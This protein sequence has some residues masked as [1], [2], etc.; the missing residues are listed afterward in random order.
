M[1]PTNAS[2]DAYTGTVPDACIWNNPDTQKLKDIFDRQRDSVAIYNR[3]NDID[4]LK[5][6]FVRANDM[7]ATSMVDKIT[8]LSNTK[9]EEVK[10]SFSLDFAQKKEQSKAIEKSLKK[11]ITL[12]YKSTVRNYKDRLTRMSLTEDELY[13]IKYLDFN[14]ALML[15]LDDCQAQIKEWGQD[16]TVNQMFFQGRHEWI[17]TI[18]LLQSD[19]S[20]GGLPP[21]VRSNTFN[22]I[23]TDPNVA[24]HFFKNEQNSFTTQ[25]KKD[26]QRIVEFLF[27]ENPN[28]VE[29]FKRFVYSRNDKH[30]RFR[31]LVAEEVED[32]FGSP[33]LWQMCERLPKDKTQQPASKFSKSFTV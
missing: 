15:I 16:V 9:L 22:N 30:A 3:A 33:A 24:I 27:K 13:A 31:Y 20:K 14:P 2:N 5:K 23:F 12:I 11:N 10:R 19:S 26:A 32:R 4:T 1:C 29:N 7:N 17:T 18:W 6:L 25:M 8:R 21:G 28:G